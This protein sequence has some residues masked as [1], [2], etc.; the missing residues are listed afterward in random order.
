MMMILDVSEQKKGGGGKEIDGVLA[1]SDS[2]DIVWIWAIVKKK[3]KHG[4]QCARIMVP[5]LL[6]FLRGTFIKKRP[7]E[8]IEAR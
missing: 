5:Y 1:R 3:L 8:A 4:R 2:I 6:C 7:S